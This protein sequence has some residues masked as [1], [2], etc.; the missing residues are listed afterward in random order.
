MSGYVVGIGS[1]AGGLEALFALLPELSANGNAAYV[2]AQH[3]VLDGH[4]DLMHKLLSRHTNLEVLL[5]NGK[6]ALQPDKIYLIPAGSDGIVEGGY[7]HLQPPAKERISTPSVNVLFRSIAESCQSNGIGVV[8]SGTGSDGVIG[9]RAIKQ[10]QGMTI[11]QDPT[12]AG[13]NGM[14]SSAIEAGV[15]DHIMPAPKIAAVITQT[16][17]NNTS[18]LHDL[19]QSHEMNNTHAPA[20]DSDE[21]QQILDLVLEKTGVN[22]TGY[23]IETIKRRLSTRMAAFKISA[24]KDYYQYLLKTPNEA[25]QLQ[26]LFLVSFSSFFRDA[27]SFYA[28]EKHL[29][30]IVNKKNDIESIDVWVPGCASG[31]EVYT[32]AIML[33]EIK[34]KLGRNNPVHIKG[35]DL[36]PLALKQARS[37]EYAAKSVKEVAP[38]RLT[39]YFTQK[40]E[41]FVVN[42]FIQ[43]MCSFEHENVFNAEQHAPLDLVSCRNLLIYFKGPLQDQLISIFHKRLVQ[44]GLLFLGQ[45]ESLSVARN[46]QF[47]SLDL[48]HRLYE[49]R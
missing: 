31:E 18:Y 29:Y 34:L 40:N 7:I 19:M 35:T 49:R 10:N 32:L 30:Q 22:F 2:I 21:L 36:N 25:Q 8:L 44:N 16:L 11:A 45:S 23:R 14:P 28:L 6:Q 20:N 39:Q 9:C 47:K 13:F 4:S 3:M 37:G 42:D 48:N 27:A 12:S 38:A 46:H 17:L 41:I 5:V 26:Q 1:S 33:A 24:L 15:I 43:Q